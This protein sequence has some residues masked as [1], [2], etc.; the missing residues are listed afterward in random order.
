MNERLEVMD[1]DW[2]QRKGTEGSNKDKKREEKERERER[3]QKP[4]RERQIKR[5]E[6]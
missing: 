5:A 3:E 4:R 1:M 6:R 2:S